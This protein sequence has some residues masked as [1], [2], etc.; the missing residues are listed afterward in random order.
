MSSPDR[1]SLR[2]LAR[3]ALVIGL[4]LPAMGCIHPLYGPTASG[5]A[6]QTKLS[7]IVID[8]VPDRLGHYLVQELGFDLNGSGTEGKARY[9]LALGATETVQSSIVSTVTGLATS[10]TL[11]GTANYVLTEVTT[12]KQIVAGSAIATATYTRN[13]QRFASLRAAR[14][15]EIRVAEQLA[16]QIR[17]RLAAKLSST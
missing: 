3:L 14:D 13:D 1:W 15:A 7:G 16:E 9:R 5:E 4:P 6:L 17:T 12:G 11:I 8:R 10:A 2:R